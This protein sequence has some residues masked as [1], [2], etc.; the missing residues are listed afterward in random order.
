MAR[1]TCRIITTT[2]RKDPVS[3]CKMFTWPIISSAGTTEV[4]QYFKSR[5]GDYVTVRGTDRVIQLLECCDDQLRKDLTRDAGGTLTEKPEDEELT[6]IRSLAVREENTMVAR[7]TLNNMRQDRDEPVWAF[8]ASRGVQ[9]YTPMH[10]VWRRDKLHGCHH[11]G[12]GIAFRWTSWGMP[13]KR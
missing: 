6:A 5:W 2:N 11:P 13:T 4:W 12:R 9:I 3:V 10:R 8:A 1:I 7:V